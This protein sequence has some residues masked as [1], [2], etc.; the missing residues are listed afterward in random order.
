MVCELPPAADDRDDTVNW[1]RD[2]PVEPVGARLTVPSV[3]P[4][5]VSVKVTLPDGGSVLGASAVT[6]AVN[7]TGSPKT[8][9]DFEVVSVALVVPWVTVSEVVPLDALKSTLALNAAV[10][11]CVPTGRALNTSAAFPLESRDLVPIGVRWPAPSSAVNVTEPKG[12][13]VGE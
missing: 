9:G 4:V 8:V 1:A 13:V 2:D 12:V 7:V 11:V 3:V 5:V 6:V 10:T